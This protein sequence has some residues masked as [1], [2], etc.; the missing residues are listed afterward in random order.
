MDDV[1]NN[2]SMQCRYS[3]PRIMV[4]DESEDILLII[5]IGSEEKNLLIDA[6]SSANPFMKIQFT[7]AFDTPLQEFREIIPAIE[8]NDIIKKLFNIGDLAMRIKHNLRG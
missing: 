1:M 5:K 4:V 6:F 3:T 8:I 7:T 2:I